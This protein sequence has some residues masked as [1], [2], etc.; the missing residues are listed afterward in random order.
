MLFFQTFRDS[1]LNHCMKV[2]ASTPNAIV[3]QVYKSL[4]LF[5]AFFLC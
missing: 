5:D 1:L 3:T 2:N 4:Q